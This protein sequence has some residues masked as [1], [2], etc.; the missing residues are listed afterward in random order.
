MDDVLC[1]MPASAYK[2]DPIVVSSQENYRSYEV[3]IPA[4]ATKVTRSK[5]K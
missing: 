1:C 3:I 4:V 5:N 2:E